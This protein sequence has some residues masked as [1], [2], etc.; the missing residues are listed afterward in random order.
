MRRGSVW[1]INLEPVSPPELG[2]VRP[3]VVIS[4]SVYVRAERGGFEPPVPEGTHD[5]ESCRFNRTHAPLPR[6]VN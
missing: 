6:Q 2:K 1:W 5:F 4:N 3:A